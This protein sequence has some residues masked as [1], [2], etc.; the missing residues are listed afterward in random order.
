M[1]FTVWKPKL[2]TSGLRASVIDVVVFGLIMSIERRGLLVWAMIENRPG[3][4]VWVY[5]SHRLLVV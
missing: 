4:V 3:Y 5:T 2:S 1:R